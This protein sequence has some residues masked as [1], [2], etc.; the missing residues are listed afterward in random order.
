MKEASPDI[1]TIGKSTCCSVDEPTIACLAADVEVA[2]YLWEE[3]NQR[4][5][6]N[7]LKAEV[8]VTTNS[9]SRR[10]IVFI[11]FDNAVV[12]TGN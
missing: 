12:H 10:S 6:T 5:D 8:T 3:Q 2:K 4:H 9:S 7:D 1:G 11:V